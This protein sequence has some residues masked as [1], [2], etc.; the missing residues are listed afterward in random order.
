MDFGMNEISWQR[1]TTVEADGIAAFSSSVSLLITNFGGGEK[2]T[3]WINR[4]DDRLGG[5][6]RLCGEMVDP[7]KGKQL[8]IT[9]G[10]F[11]KEDEFENIP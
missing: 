5:K 8:F 2:K 4:L 9:E 3:P 6:R 1:T 10:L 7:K 11:F